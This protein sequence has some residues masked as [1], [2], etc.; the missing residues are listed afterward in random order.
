MAFLRNSE[1]QR[2]RTHSNLYVD[3]SQGNKDALLSSL[4]AGAA[5]DEMDSS[6]MTPLT[7]AAW[8]GHLDCVRLL[9]GRG[10][11]VHKKSADGF[12]AAHYAALA[13]FTELLLTLFDAG[14]AVDVTDDFDLRTPLMYACRQW[15]HAVCA[16]A[17]RAWC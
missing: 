1:P 9:I 10:P 7:H 16:F 6:R 5:I 17:A 11:D 15:S 2:T 14:V 12:T 4:D 13:G 8:N 3:A